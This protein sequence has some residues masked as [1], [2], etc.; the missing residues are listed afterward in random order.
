M[1]TELPPSLPP[2]AKAETGV[3][4]PELTLVEAIHQTLL[5]NP[6]LQSATERM[7]IADEALARARADFF[8]LLAFNE[9]YQA[10]SNDAQKFSFFTSEGILNPAFLFNPPPVADALQTQVQVRQDIYTGGLRLAQTRSAAAERDSARFGLASVQNRIVF[11]VAEAYY[12]LFQARELVNVRGAAVTQVESELRAVQARF[13]AQTAVRSDVLRVQVRLEEV[14]EALITALSEHELAWAVLENVTGVRLA[15]RSLPDT[16][17]AAPWSDQIGDVE[18][19]VTQVEQGGDER[20]GLES[21]VAEALARRPEV[22]E[23]DSERQAAEHRVR[24]A[25]AGKCPTLGVVADYDLFAGSTGAADDSFFVGLAFSLN[26]FDGGR[27][28]ASV[29]RA[30]AQVREIIARNQRLKL[31]IELELRRAYLQLQ[32]ARERTK[33]AAA[34]VS[35]GQES[36]RQVEAQYRN[37]TATVTQIIEAQV[38]VSEA[39]VRYTNA[40]ADVEVARAALARAIGRLS[41]FLAP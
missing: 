38:A 33:V 4:V 11:Q 16:L 9:N 12:R 28:R 25:E 19:A 13:R 32:E 1:A 27:T 2:A 22:G 34:A 10:S 3:G 29:R 5:A 6:D 40:R 39:R 8:P 31:D 36:L 24:A 37:E 15:G 20:S 23:G 26:L 21:A 7:R 14:R 41:D 30:E 18:A 17:P 35:S